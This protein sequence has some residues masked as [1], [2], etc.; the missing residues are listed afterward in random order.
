MAIAQKELS[1]NFNSHAH[2][3]RDTGITVTLLVHCNFNSH[4]HE[5]RD[6]VVHMKVATPTISTHTPTRGVTLECKNIDFVTFISTHT[7]T[8]GVTAAHLRN[9]EKTIIS[10]HTPTR[11]VT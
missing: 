2:E 9:V 1:S 11:G 4:A 5:G 10:T 6:I 7:P 8:R 3:G